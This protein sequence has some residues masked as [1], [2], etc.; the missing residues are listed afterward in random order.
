MWLPVAAYRA[1]IQQICDSVTIISRGRRVTTG[2]VQ[3]VLAQHDKGGYRVRVADHR[4][5]AG[6]IAE[7]GLRVS[8]QEDHFVVS[9]LADPAWISQTL[10]QRGLWVSELTRLTPDHR[11]P[12]RKAPVEFRLLKLPGRSYY[13]TLRDKLRW[14]VPPNYRTEPGGD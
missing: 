6:V 7:A 10:G 14:G 4:R 8:I 2:P 5:A 1:E 12:V 3:E 11:V 9:D 13:Q